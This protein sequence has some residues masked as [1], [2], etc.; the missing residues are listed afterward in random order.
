MV[1]IDLKGDHSGIGIPRT[2][3]RAL[4]CPPL[5]SSPIRIT[6]DLYSFI[7]IWLDGFQ[8]HLP[9]AT[10]L[11]RRFLRVA[12]NMAPSCWNMASGDVACS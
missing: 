10:W 6:L 3:L 2:A 1:I 4:A 11:H 5:P 8:F 7:L 9:F 12:Q